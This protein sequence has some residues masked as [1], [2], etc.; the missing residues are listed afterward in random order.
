M[1]FILKQSTVFSHT[2]LSI[3][4]AFDLH[5]SENLFYDEEL[6]CKSSGV[7]ALPNDKILESTKFKADNKS[8]D[9]IENIVRKGENGGCQH[10]LLFPQWFYKVSSS[11]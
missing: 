7:N 1:F 5:R 9:R 3:A 11:G 8:N 10:F 2:F 6:R 4:N